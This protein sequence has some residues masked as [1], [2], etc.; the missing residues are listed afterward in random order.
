M[1]LNREL[2]LE[3]KKTNDLIYNEKNVSDKIPPLGKEGVKNVQW[4]FDSEAENKT[5]GG[6]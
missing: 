2:K 1:E 3:F 5:V 6:D 4:T